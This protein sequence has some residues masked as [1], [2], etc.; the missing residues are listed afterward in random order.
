MPAS[1]PNEEGY[2]IE[3]IRIFGINKN[4]EN[5]KVETVNTVKAFKEKN[6][7]KI[8]NLI[9][10]CDDILYTEEHTKSQE[11]CDI[12][13]KIHSVCYTFITLLNSYMKGSTNEKYAVV[14]ALSRILDWSE[15]ALEKV[16]GLLAQ[17]K[18]DGTPDKENVDT[19]E[20]IVCEF[21]QYVV[22]FAQ[23]IFFDLSK[24]EIWE[25]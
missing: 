19:A 22:E 17:M 15:L 12:C 4:N 3:L 24:G 7:E 18:S 11:L 5:K 25:N 13:R 21:K 10:Y 9:Q 20:K 14:I 16:E 1:N 6:A 2:S 8:E 23:D